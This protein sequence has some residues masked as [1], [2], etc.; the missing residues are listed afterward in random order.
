MD[1]KI[2]PIIN[3]IKKQIT[4]AR[5]KSMSLVNKELIKM[6]W[7]IGKT[8]TE[9]RIDKWGKSFIENISKEIQN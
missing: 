9:S 1:V 3:E 6:Y 7:N 4:N 2:L 5:Y 8:L